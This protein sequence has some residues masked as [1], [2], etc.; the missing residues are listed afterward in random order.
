SS[1]EIAQYKK[2][3]SQPGA[4]TAMLNYYRANIVKRMFGKNEI[5]PKID[6]PTLFIYGEKDK[7][8]LPQTVAGVGDMI[9]GPYQEHRIPN[10]G[11]WVQQ[12]ASEQVTEILRKFLD[13]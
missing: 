13:D 7:A 3:W 4:T 6:V 8:V 12:E 5:P 9:A 11:H 10:S 2:A 1:D